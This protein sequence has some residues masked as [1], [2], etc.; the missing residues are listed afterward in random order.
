MLFELRTTP[1]GASILIG[2][3]VR[4][5]VLDC[6]TAPKLLAELGERCRGS[7]FVYKPGPK[8]W[9]ERWSTFAVL[10]QRFEGRAIE[11]DSVDL[12]IA[13]GAAV[14][15]FSP[16]SQLS[17]CLNTGG[18][19]WLEVDGQPFD[20]AAHLGAP[21]LSREEHSSPEGRSAVLSGPSLGCVE[22]VEGEAVRRNLLVEVRTTLQGVTWLLGA[23]ADINL[24]DCLREPQMNADLKMRC[25]L[26]SAQGFLYRRD[27][28]WMPDRW[29]SFAVHHHDAK[30][31]VYEDDCEG[32]AS[33]YAAALAQ[34]PGRLVEVAITQ[35]EPGR[36]AHAYNKID[37]EVWDPSVFNTMKPPP[38]DFYSTGET[39][40]VQ[41]E[42]SCL[43][44]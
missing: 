20:P 16:A 35:P 5:T 3:M 1:Y 29:T 11:G 9:P 25:A 14:R 44:S 28:A 23:L 22:A 17:V 15:L 32:Q 40:T 36:M 2:A 31:D 13:F 21:A 19:A 33:F 30:S 7:G 37:G 4:C 43:D 24:A 39:A 38:K 42:S 10:S 26:P 41:V 8:H 18:R 12:A 34:Q 27:P 6:T